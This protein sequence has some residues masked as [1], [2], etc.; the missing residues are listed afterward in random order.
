MNFLDLIWLIPLFPAMG[1]VINGLFGKRLPK[2]VIGVI[3]CG[4]SL[5]AF[6]FA[7]GAV[8]QL[9]Q[10]EPGH[11]VHTVRLYEW[12]NAGPSHNAEGG[13]TRFA[14]D[15]SFLLDLQIL[16]KTWSAIAHVE[17]AY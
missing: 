8:F 14:I 1:F 4:A 9:L 11:R 7:A 13:L 2:S 10:L 5:I 6:I 15:W 16:W 3:A 12:I 17:G